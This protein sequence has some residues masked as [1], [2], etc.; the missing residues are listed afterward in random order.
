M[1]NFDLQE[2][3][4]KR[5]ILPFPDGPKVVSK[6]LEAAH[7]DILEAKDRLE[8]GKYKYATIT[9]YYAIFHVFRALLYQ[10]NYREK[11]HIQLAF[12]IN[13]KLILC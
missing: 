5:K 9:A 7:A 8:N 2:A 4:E 12:A 11:S 1:K 6:E 10:K 3:I 13:I